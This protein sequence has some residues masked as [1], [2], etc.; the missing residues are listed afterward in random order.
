MRKVCFWLIIFNSVFYSQQLKLGGTAN[1][2]VSNDSITYLFGPG[3][4]FE[5]KFIDL[6]IS[7]QGSTN[8]Y[9]G[10]IKDVGNIT[11]AA[12]GASLNYFPIKA[13]IEP[14]LAIGIFYN[15]YHT[16]D[17]PITHNNISGE[18]KFGLNLSPKNKIN[19]ITEICYDINQLPL[20]TYNYLIMKVSNHNVNLNTIIWKF[21]LM[22]EL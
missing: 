6:P 16:D 19:I 20:T 17:G 5:Y 2:S 15:F 1:F 14:Y 22:T 4:R 13:F 12:L 11:C 9:I 21:G 8:Y 7:V 10:E 18:L 3:L